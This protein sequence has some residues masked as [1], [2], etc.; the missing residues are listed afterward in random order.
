MPGASRLERLEAMAQE[1]AGTF[2]IDP[3]VPPTSR[4]AFRQMGPREEQRAARLEAET[5][6]WCALREVVEVPAP[7]V[8]FDEAASAAEVDA[9]LRELARC[10]AGWDDVVGYCAA[11]VK[12]SGLFRL[13]GFASFRQYCHERLGVGAR[14]V[15][16]RSVVEKRRRTSTALEAAK[17]RG[18]PFEKLRLLARLPEAEI[19]AWSERAEA[20]TCIAL[21]RALQGNA[22]RQMRAQR[23]LA[24]ALP[25]RVA[26][27]VAAAVQAVRDRVRRPLPF[28][29]CLAVVAAHFLETWRGVAP[30]SRSR[31]RKVRDRDEGHCLVPGCSHRATHAHHVLFRSHGGGDDP[32]NQIAI[33]AFHHLRCIHGGFLRVVGRAPAALRWF[34]NGAPWTGPRV[35][36]P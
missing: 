8:T 9:T 31:S 36:A 35:A 2:P 20:M 32:E 6:R 19:A 16:E 22:E 26:E 11:A 21:R 3:H 29:T 14:T 12:D 27:V 25:F 28:G 24:V 4:A 15:E 13:L 7:E 18:L 5:E 34:L 1:F 33:C 30:R 17:R 23:Q 10:R